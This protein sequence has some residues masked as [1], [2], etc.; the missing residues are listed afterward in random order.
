MTR[1]TLQRGRWYACELI[2]DEFGEDKCSYSPIKVF[3]VEPQKSGNR[4]F[5]LKF[6]HASYPAGV[7]T[8][9]TSWR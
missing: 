4:K 7:R 9:I 3:A 2:G 6:Y 1:F 5:G 8:S